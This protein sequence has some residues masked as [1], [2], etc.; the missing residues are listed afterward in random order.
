MCTTT[1]TGVGR[2]PPPAKGAKRPMPEVGTYCVGRL[3]KIL[4]AL[5]FWK[6]RPYWRA[7]PR[8]EVHWL[9]ALAPTF[10]PV[11]VTVSS[12]GWLVLKI[13]VLAAVV[14]DETV[15]SPTLASCSSQPFFESRSDCA[16]ACVVPAGQL[17]ALCR[18]P[19]VISERLVSAITAGGL[20]GEVTSASVRLP[21]LKS[22][23]M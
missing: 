15:F 7:V 17:E 2:K 10:W 13:T 5:P 3:A 22:F 11:P 4:F 9:L 21:M 6:F 1:G 23:S 14:A 18:Q 8:S 12:F 20:L 19:F 16:S